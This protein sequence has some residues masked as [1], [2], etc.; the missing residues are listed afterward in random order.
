MRSSVIDRKLRY[1]EELFI[2]LKEIN[3]DISLTGDP[4]LLL[5]YEEKKIVVFD[6]IEDHEQD[7]LFLLEAYIDDCKTENLPIVLE[8][9]RVFKELDIARR[10]KL[11]SME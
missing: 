6:E 4:S 10:Y 5:E 7:A 11:L 2:D 8:Y 1:L 3:Y 9:Y